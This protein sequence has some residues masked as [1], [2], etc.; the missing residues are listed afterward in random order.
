MGLWYGAWAALAFATRGELGPLS[1][2]MYVGV[3]PMLVYYC[4]GAAFFLVER[5]QW[6][7]RRLQPL[8]PSPSAEDFAK[9]LTGATWNW[10][11]VGL[12]WAWLMSSYVMPWRAQFATVE[13]LLKDIPLAAFAVEVVVDALAVEALFYV[14]HRLL[15]TRALYSRIHSQHHEFTAPFAIAAI[16]ANPV[17]HLLSNV[18]PVSAGPF[19]AGASPQAACAW[20]CLAIVNTMISHSGYLIPGLHDPSFHDWHHESSTENF[21]VLGIC[22]S[23]AGS[24]VRYN[25]ALQ[26]GRYDL[27][28]KAATDL[29]IA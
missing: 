23:I 2:F 14:F 16:Y 10:A 20:A 7:S 13:G 29:K 22:D 15:H 3:I 5:P 4:A 25:A 17:E 24:S 6:H 12:P 19:I 18:V 27:P 9:A 8:A 21:G 1:T 28:R 11:L 26:A